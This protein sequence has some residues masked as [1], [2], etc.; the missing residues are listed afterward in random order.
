MEPKVLWHHG[1]AKTTARQNAA[2]TMVLFAPATFVGVSSPG[3]P[4]SQ[5]G[6]IILA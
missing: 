4:H 1:T 2:A 3:G 6:D 5:L